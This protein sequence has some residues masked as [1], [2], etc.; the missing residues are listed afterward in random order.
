MAGEIDFRAL[1]PGINY[2]ELIASF[3][4]GNRSQVA[5]Q[6]AKLEASRLQ[7]LADEEANKAKGNEAMAAWFESMGGETA[8]VAA[9]AAAPT[10]ALTP[11][12]NAPGAGVAPPADAPE[13]DITVT[14]QREPKPNPTAFLAAMARAGQGDVA[15][16]L[17]EQTR[18]LSKEQ[19]ASAAEAYT[20]MDSAFAT[21]ATV[22]YEQRKALIAQMA[23][24]LI[25][26]G[27]PEA[28]IAGFDPTDAAITAARNSTL[29]IK[30]L[31]EFEDKAADNARQERALALTERGQNI[32]LRGQDL[33]DARAAQRNSID[34]YG[35]DKATR[36]TE[37]DLRK[38]F[39]GLQEV[40]DWRQI[41]TSYRQIR[42]AAANPSAQNDMSLIF[43]YMKM[44]DPGSVVREGEFATAQNAAGVPD[45]VRNLY[46]RAQS[47]E[48]LNP[49]QRKG[50]VE[51]AAQVVLSRRDRFNAITDYYRKLATDYGTDADRVA[52]PAPVVT[53]GAAAGKPAAPVRIRGNAEYAKLPSGTVFIAPDGSR[54]VKP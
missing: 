24:G 42:R 40:K 2:G 45:Q 44:L 53:P 9:P 51:S 46:N 29:G 31:L 33:A 19:R 20:A 13:A 49:E 6:T 26:R 39:D 36:K 14:A 7:R 4:A 11:V 34:A 18:A 37:T 35:V 1:S 8:P 43:S 25:A 50:M 17:F 30:G 3:D 10:A 38:E 5:R 47:G 41:T 27:V 22:P 15:M 48:R 54:R 52:R 23:P 12:A 32:T 16:K 28:Q 21:L